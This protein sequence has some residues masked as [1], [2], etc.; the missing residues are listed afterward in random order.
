M[1]FCSVGQTWAEETRSVQKPGQPETISTIIYV[2][3]NKILERHS[4]INLRTDS[5]YIVP[6][7]LQNKLSFML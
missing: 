4:L 3:L 5:K 7:K 1:V 6:R 2:E